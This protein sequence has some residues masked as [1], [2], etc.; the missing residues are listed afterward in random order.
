MLDPPPSWP[1]ARPMVPLLFP[2]WSVSESV[3][4]GISYAG[5]VC[6]RRGVLP[7]VPLFL[8]CQLLMAD[9]GIGAVLYAASR[10]PMQAVSW[11][12]MKCVGANVFSQNSPQSR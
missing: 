2:G 4:H 6:H 12:Q 7:S 1:E 9:A 8:P 10:C 3:G 11:V 5:S